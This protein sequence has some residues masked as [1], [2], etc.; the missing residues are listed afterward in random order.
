MS[1]GT[2]IERYIDGKEKKSA[3]DTR[4]VETQLKAIRYY[5]FFNV[6]V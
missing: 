2:P 3:G 6:C 4:R 5:D 1:D